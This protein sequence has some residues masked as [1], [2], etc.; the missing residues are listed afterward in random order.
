MLHTATVSQNL[1]SLPVFRHV[2]GTG[3]R[4]YFGVTQGTYGHTSLER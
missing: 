3:G 4:Q 2:E 1:G